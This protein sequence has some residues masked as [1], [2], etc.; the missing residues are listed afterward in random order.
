MGALDLL[1]CRER[2]ALLKR[3]ALFNVIW[4][5]VMTGVSLHYF[6][7]AP[8]SGLVLALAVFTLAWWKL[9]AG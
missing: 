3:V 8:T 6:F 5:A 1:L 7:A 4:L 9:P 2:P